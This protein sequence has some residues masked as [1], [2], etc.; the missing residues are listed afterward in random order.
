MRNKPE[1]TDEDKE[2]KIYLAIREKYGYG[3]EGDALVDWLIDNIEP[4]IYNKGE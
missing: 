3:E 2:N 4:S 1:S